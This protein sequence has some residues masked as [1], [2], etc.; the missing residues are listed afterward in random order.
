M[1]SIWVGNFLPWKLTNSSLV[2]VSVTVV[3]KL[4]WMFLSKFSKSVVICSYLVV[5][6][7]VEI[8]GV[9]VIRELV[10]CRGASMPVQ[11]S[12]SKGPASCFDSSFNLFNSIN[13][14]KK[15]SIPEPCLV[16]AKLSQVHQTPTVFFSQVAADVSEQTA[17]AA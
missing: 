10:N 16:T 11:S 7:I 13:I 15:F 5:L 6:R 14:L 2:K 4:R 3:M 1:S 9:G 8:V 17:A 12:L